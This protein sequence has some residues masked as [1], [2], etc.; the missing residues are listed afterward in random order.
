METALRRPP[1]RAGEVEVRPS[2]FLVLVNGERLHV[3]VRELELLTALVERR[4]RIVT[5]EELYREVWG[6]PYRKSDRSVDVYVGKL[7]QKLED[8]VPGRRFIHTHFG[9][10]YRFAPDSDRG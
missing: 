7:R 2:E 10:G 3:T 1:L 6:E 9:F 8:A 4:N 5:R